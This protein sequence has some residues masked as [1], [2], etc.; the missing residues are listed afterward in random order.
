MDSYTE[1]RDHMDKTSRR[2]DMKSATVHSNDFGTVF[3]FRFKHG[4]SKFG[5]QTRINDTTEE[6]RTFVMSERSPHQIHRNRIRAN[7]YKFRYQG[8]NSDIEIEKPRKCNSETSPCFDPD[9]SPVYQLDH[10]I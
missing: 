5:S 1:V 4:R 9:Y 3:T 8:K 10:T 2:M 6:H 7:L